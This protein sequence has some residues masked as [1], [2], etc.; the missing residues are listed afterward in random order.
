MPK[1]TQDE[2]GITKVVAM[3]YSACLRSVL[4]GALRDCR[5]TRS[6]A[7]KTYGKHV[8]TII[9]ISYFRQ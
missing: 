5:V 1:K 2:S 9:T 8:G 6:I 7:P 4:E 3:S